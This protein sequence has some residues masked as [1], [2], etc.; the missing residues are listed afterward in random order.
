MAK[1]ITKIDTKFS[2]KKEKKDKIEE[3]KEVEEI[4][5]IK[6]ELDIELDHSKIPSISNKTDI[7]H[8]KKDYSKTVDLRKV[9]EKIVN[10]NKKKNDKKKEE[11]KKIK[12]VEKKKLLTDTEI[13]ILKEKLNIKNKS[14][15]FTSHVKRR[16]KIKR[17]K[18]LLLI[19]FIL[20]IF[21]VIA[22]S[23]HLTLFLIN[24]NKTE[25]R[26]LKESEIAK[27]IGS[28]Y[29]KF[30]KIVNESK[31]YSDVAMKEEIGTIF[32]DYKVELKEEEIYYTKKA[33]FIPE[34]NGYINYKD[35][36]PIE[37]IDNNFDQRYKNYGYFNLNL[38]TKSGFTLYD[39]DGTNLFKLNTSM[40]F[41]IIVN[42]DEGKY[43][44]NYNDRFSYILSDDVETVY[45]QNNG[46]IGIPD[47]ITTLCYHTVKDSCSDIYVCRQKDRYNS[48]L[49]AIKNSGYFT[50]TLQ[51]MYWYMYEL[52]NLPKKSVL[53]TFDDGYE[54]PN[55]IEGL[56]KYD[57]HGNSFLV[58]SWVNDLDQYRDSHIS[59]GSH[60]HNMHNTWECKTGNSKIGSSTQGGG[61]LCKPKDYVLEDLKKSRSI[62]DDTN[63][64]CYP[65]YDFNDYSEGLAKEAGFKIA[66]I[67]AYGGYRTSHNDNPYRIRRMTIWDTTQTSKVLQYVQGT[68]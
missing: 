1:K 58:T 59:F 23:I 27:E 40:D 31:I 26:L 14:L 49:E 56:K 19:A 43:Y 24:K 66:F 37:K 30:V 42:N 68:A 12:V 64:L 8:K 48:D 16:V 4:E 41:P 67:G 55:V 2:S 50:L 38:K 17:G 34:F 65:F 18:K 15:V 61:I 60:T 33:F 3:I 10:K 13:N 7:K 46:A 28:H 6:E 52:V 36:S 57:L 32:G 51:E 25:K 9:K 39:S 29:G 35:V 63:A 44:V 62:A 45:N 20:C 53:I 22:L 54:L 21:L 47:R 5:E 11:P